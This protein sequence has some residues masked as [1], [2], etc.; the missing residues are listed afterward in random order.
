[1]LSK[2]RTSYA[3]KTIMYYVSLFVFEFYKLTYET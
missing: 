1:M 2:V 3:E